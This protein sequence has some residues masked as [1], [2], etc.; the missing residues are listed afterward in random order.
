[1]LLGDR[2]GCRDVS[3]MD[4]YA[5]CIAPDATDGAILSEKSPAGLGDV[6][7]QLIP[8]VMSV[9]VIDPLEMIAID[10]GDAEIA[11]GAAT[12]AGQSLQKPRAVKR[13]RQRIALGDPLD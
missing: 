10:D 13:P 6:P 3:V 9:A 7:Q 11:S 5:E 8:H 1:E 2:T 12:T 4:Q